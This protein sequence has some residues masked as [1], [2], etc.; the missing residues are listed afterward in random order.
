MKAINNAIP[1]AKFF[2]KENWVL[3]L[4]HYRV[5]GSKA[6]TRIPMPNGKL[7]ERAITTYLVNYER[8]RK[9][10]LLWEPLSNKIYSA[11]DVSFNE[12][13]LYTHRVDDESRFGKVELAPEWE[14]E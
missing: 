8:E 10:Y 12:N 9:A 7:S 2:G 14:Q 1:I 6:M 4:K 3:N 13:I 5:L 11:L